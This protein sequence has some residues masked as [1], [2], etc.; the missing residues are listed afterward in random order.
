MGPIQWY[1]AWQNRLFSRHLFSPQWKAA[2]SVH[3]PS[4]INELPINQHRNDI[5]FNK[6]IEG[7][8]QCS[9]SLPRAPGINRALQAKIKMDNLPNGVEKY[10]DVDLGASA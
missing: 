3:A 7:Y 4:Q 9:I 5:K 2:A 10:F 8:R 1:Q 6:R